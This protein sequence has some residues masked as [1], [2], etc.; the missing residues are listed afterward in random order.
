MRHEHR[1]EEREHG[2]RPRGVVPSG[3]VVADHKNWKAQQ[4]D[5]GEALALEAL[6][7]DDGAPHDVLGGVV[8]HDEAHAHVVARAVGELRGRDLAR[9]AVGQQLVV[10]VLCKRLKLRGRVGGGQVARQREGLV[11]VEGHLTCA[12]STPSVDGIGTGVVILLEDDVKVE[13]LALEVVQVVLDAAAAL[14]VGHLRGGRAVRRV[15]AVVVAPV[16]LGHVAVGED[17]EEGDHP[18]HPNP[19]LLVKGEVGAALHAEFEETRAPFSNKTP[20]HPPTFSRGSS[21]AIAGTPPGRAC[22][23]P[24]WGDRRK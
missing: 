14:E 20:T 2:Q 3:P 21:P 6:A 12:A 13:G 11:P 22:D 18:I 15:A 16:V 10:C 24:G 7:A 19:T 17:G 4:L 23:P 8:V 5:W 1:H 9:R